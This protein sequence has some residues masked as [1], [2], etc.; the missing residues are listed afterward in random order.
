M[1]NPLDY[2]TK[3]QIAEL[4]LS[5]DELSTAYQPSG[6]GVYH[7][8]GAEDACKTLWIAKRYKYLIDSGQY[9]PEAAFG[10]MTFKG[11]YGWGYTVLKGEKLHEELHRITNPLN[12]A[13]H[14]IAIIDE[15]D[16][17]FP[18][19]FFAGR[20][21]TEIAL[22][23]WHIRKLHTNIL[24]SS[25]IGNS[26]DLIFHLASHFTILPEGINWVKDCIDFTVINR[27]DKQ[28]SY[29]S[30]YNV[31]QAM[32]IY[33]RQELTEGEDNRHKKVKKN[34]HPD[35]LINQDDWSE[36]PSDNLPIY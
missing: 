20:E 10:N 32:L 22:R 30:V 17:E 16:T 1:P 33:S 19:R 35:E 13:K 27:L 8:R 31:I 5:P 28:I 18:A 24:M 6:G 34:N 21:Q 14:K 4:Q 12:P 25:H 29:W 23:M 9:S 11:K 2:L 3:E 7:C 15:I 26:T 36:I